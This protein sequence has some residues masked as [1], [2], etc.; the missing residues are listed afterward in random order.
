MKTIA[1]PKKVRIL[2]GDSLRTIAARYLLDQTRWRELVEL[3]HLRPPY[4]VN[5]IDPVDRLPQTLIMGD[6][7][8]LPLSYKQNTLVFDPEILGRDLELNY[9]KGLEA[10]SSGD[11]STLVGVPNLN[12]AV[13]NR[14]KCSRGSNFAH[15]TYGSDIYAVLGLPMIPLIEIFARMTVKQTLKEEPR[16]TE[17]TSIDVKANRRHA[18]L[19]G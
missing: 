2:E 17:V 14:F 13:R 6:W 4:I 8:D 16:L 11:L 10:S 18:H 7:I 5:S 9:E 1:N 3:N 15:R 12:Q 19:F